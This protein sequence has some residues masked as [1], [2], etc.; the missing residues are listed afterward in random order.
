MLMKY[1]VLKPNDSSVVEINGTCNFGQSYKAF[2]WSLAMLSTL[3]REAGHDAVMLDANLAELSPEET[4]QAL[5]KLRPDMV[6][7]PVNPVLMKRSTAWLRFWHGPTTVLLNEPFVSWVRARLPENAELIYGDWF[8]QMLGQTILPRDY[9]V[10]DASRFGAGQYTRHQMLVS[11]GCNHACSF[12]HFGRTMHR[13][14]SGRPISVVLAEMRSFR[15]T[16][17]R[18]LSIF[19]NELALDRDYCLELM[20]AMR[21]A[22]L[23]ILW[24]TNTRVSSLD[25]IL[26]SSMAGAGLTYSGYG[27][28]CSVQR[29]LDAN[30]K[31]I[32]VEQILDA[33]RLFK[34]H[35]V[36]ARTYVLIG[37]IGQSR[38]DVLATGAFLDKLGQKDSSFELVNPM[39]DTP[40][41][42]GLRRQGK[43]RAPCSPANMAWIASQLDD[44]PLLAGEEKEE[45]QWD[46][47][48]LSFSEALDLA[49]QMRSKVREATF[50]EKF[51]ALSRHP[52]GLTMALATATRKASNVFSARG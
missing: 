14:W 50:M 52:H 30:N 22:R 33:A 44:V 3:L 12:C 25:D 18:F 11:E 43:L 42:T 4:A 39:Q 17:R 23:D 21:S 6:L 29:V 48:R 45:P 36:L 16:G 1:V 46:Y 8:S 51:R 28:E 47:D 9:P 7:A 2:P 24:E 34:K 35:G 31:E 38:D 5:I 26:V 13:G 27:V 37:L 41:E 49:R 40:L 20:A 15:T 32:S 19:D 10:L